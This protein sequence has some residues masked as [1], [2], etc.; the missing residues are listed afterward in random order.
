MIT[1]VSI[2]SFRTRL[3]TLLKVKRGVYSS[4][5]D[6][7][8]HSFQGVTIEQIRQNRDMILISN[9]AVVIKMRMPDKKQRLSKAD[10]YRL[11]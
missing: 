3:A 2:S 10:G 5:P 11:I 4:V 1:F 9:D 6:E 8:C 7:I